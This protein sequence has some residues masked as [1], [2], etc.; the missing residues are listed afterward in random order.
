MTNRDGTRP[1]RNPADP[2]RIE[3]IPEEVTS[4][5]VEA[6]LTRAWD[7]RRPLHAAADLTTYRLFHGFSEGIN[8]LEI[9][10]YGEAVLVV[11]KRRFSSATIEAVVQALD[12]HRRFPAIGLKTQVRGS[13]DPT[14]R[15]FRMLRG[16]S[17][18]EPVVVVE[19]RLRFATEPFDRESTGL[20]LD[21][22]PIRE[23]LLESSDNRSILNL[24]SHAGSLGVAAAVGGAQRV[25]HVDAKAQPLERARL[26]H[27]LN[28][29]PSDPRDFMRGD[30]Y[31]HLPRAA[32]AG[33]TFD[34]VILDPPPQ[35]PRRKKKRPIGQDYPNLMRCVGPLLA[36]GAWVACFF[37]RYERTREEYE[38]EVVDHCPAAI[39]PRLRLES[40]IDFPESNS[41]AKLQVTVFF[42]I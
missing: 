14:A 16:E 32:R 20:F 1:D 41:H 27:E 24:F 7:L 3:A 2:T 18:K 11:E 23:W 10:R 36:P 12:R 34:G 13:L 17:P 31:V 28:G 19:P 8:G 33:Q 42:R 21:A 37:H 5:E 35:M 4:A 22:R 9:E 40:G 25:T 26:N 6:A 30:L 38:A 15:R 29:L 39:E